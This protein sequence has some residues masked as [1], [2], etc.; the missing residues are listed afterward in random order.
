MPDEASAVPKRTCSTCGRNLTAEQRFC[1]RCGAAL[2]SWERE[3][4]IAPDTATSEPT[5]LRRREFRFSAVLFVLMLS[6]FAA[7]AIAAKF[8]SPAMTIV[9]ATAV[10]AAIVFGFVVGRYRLIK[11]FLRFPRV[12]LSQI[13]EL[14]LLAIVAF[15]GLAAYFRILD[16]LGVP[17]VDMTADLYAANWTRGEVIIA[18]CVLPALLE[19]LALRGVVQ[20]SLERVLE[21]RE[22][23]LVQAALFSVLHISPIIF[24]SHF[25]LGLTLG[26]MRSK[27]R[28]VYPGMLFH[29]AWNLYAI[30]DTTHSIS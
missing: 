24:P 21:W 5:L 8:V 11:P 26:Y 18:I 16:G 1:P 17:I 29:A 7:E 19:E 22:A 3:Q 30:A 20:T 15:L 27:T 4:Q 14:L 6:I 10:Q 13:P 28:S 2:G 23:L 25:I 12:Q 9:L